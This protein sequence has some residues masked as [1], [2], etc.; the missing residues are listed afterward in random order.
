[1]LVPV[2]TSDLVASLGK[3]P[4]PIRSSDDF[5]ALKKLGVAGAVYLAIGNQGKDDASIKSLKPILNAVPCCVGPFGPGDDTHAANFLDAGCAHVVFDVDVS[6]TD[7][8]TAGE[9]EGAGSRPSVTNIAETVASLSSGRVLL[10]LKGAPVPSNGTIPAELSAAIMALKQYCS[11]IIVEVESA[12]IPGEAIKQLRALSSAHVRLLAQAA[13][14]AVPLKTAEVARLHRHEV[15]AL[16]PA[17]LSM[18]DDEVSTAEAAGK[19]DIGACF[20]ACIRSDRPDGLFT[21]V[22]QDESGH[23]L[24]LVYSSKESVL[25]AIRVGR[26]VYYSRS[27]WVQ[28]T[29]SSA[30]CLFALLPLLRI[31]EAACG[32]RATRVGTSKCYG[33]CA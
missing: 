33:T 13:S 2:I 29:F 30:H 4:E 32:A 10:R 6:I 23:T 5:E 12:A 16:A 17:V 27:R 28:G 15:S 11:G 9:S 24:G 19:L 21:T 8:Q 20:V 31:A 14:G 3:L 1:M 18:S 25:E 26:G 22:V 7:D